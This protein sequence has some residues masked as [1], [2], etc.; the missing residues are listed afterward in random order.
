MSLRK[1]PFA[2]ISFAYKLLMLIA[3]LIP[4][5]VELLVMRS[6]NDV[7]KPDQLISSEI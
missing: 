3:E 4:K 5:G 7:T 1:E 2:R 6:M